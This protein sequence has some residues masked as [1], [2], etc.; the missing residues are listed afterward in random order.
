MSDAPQPLRVLFLCTGNS[1]RSQ[2]AEALLRHESKG[3]IEVHSAGTEPQ[4]EI[5][6]MALQALSELYRLEMT[7]QHPKSV[8]PFI[9]QPFDYVITVCDRAAETC[10]VFPGA[11]QRIHWGFPDP[12]AADG[13]EDARQRAFNRT[14]SELLARIRV[15]LSLPGIRSRL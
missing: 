12:A 8:E 10:P 7:G 6:P 5:H 13:S 15:W 11:P 3:R 1:A 2:M 14:A 9:G 4:P